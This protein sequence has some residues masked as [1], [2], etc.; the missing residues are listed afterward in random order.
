MHAIKHGTYG[1][2]DHRKKRKE[3]KI[4]IDNENTGSFRF[5]FPNNFYEDT[6]FGESLGRKNRNTLNDNR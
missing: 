6:I 4:D 2:N 3:N 1:N 5:H